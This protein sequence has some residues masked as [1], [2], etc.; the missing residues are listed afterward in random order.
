MKKFNI[1]KTTKEEDNIIGCL[2]NFLYPEHI[3]MNNPEGIWSV[4]KSG[5]IL[6]ETS[7][8]WYELIRSN[9]LPDLIERIHKIKKGL[10]NNM[11]DTIDDKK[12]DQLEIKYYQFDGYEED[13]EEFLCE[14]SNFNW[15]TIFYNLNKILTEIKDYE[16][17]ISNGKADA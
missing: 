1:I 4:H 9:I 5:F 6:P 3:L 14:E 15:Q 10:Q 7:I 13:I 16:Q 2:C 11:N 12:E 17:V 8:H